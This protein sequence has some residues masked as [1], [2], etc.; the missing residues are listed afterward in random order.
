MDKKAMK[1]PAR[2]A[3]VIWFAV[4]VVVLVLTALV[5]MALLPGQHGPGRHL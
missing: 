4:V 3:W 5:L 2:P 1:P